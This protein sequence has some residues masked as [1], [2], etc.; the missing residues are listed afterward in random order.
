MP[1][2]EG[3]TNRC[4]TDIR[5]GKRAVEPTSSV[6]SCNPRVSISPQPIFRERV[7]KGPEN[8]ISVLADKTAAHG[9]NPA[10]DKSF[11]QHGVLATGRH[12]LIRLPA[13]TER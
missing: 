13:G 3:P 6:D 4:A 8:P 11:W 12:A 2:R 9:T 1:R 10:H 5:T 7:K